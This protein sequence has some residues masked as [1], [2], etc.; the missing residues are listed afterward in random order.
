MLHGHTH[1]P[2]CT[3]HETYTYINPGSVSIPKEESAIVSGTV[4]EYQAF[5]K[6]LG[7]EEIEE[8]EDNTIFSEEDALEAVALEEA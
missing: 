5:I 3:E 1:V 8:I 4:S 7:K 6:E 2:K